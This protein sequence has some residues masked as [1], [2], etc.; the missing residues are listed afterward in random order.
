MLASF[1]S[2][3]GQLVLKCLQIF[4]KTNENGLL[5]D[6]K[7]PKGHFKINWPLPK[8]YEYPDFFFFGKIDSSL[9][10]CTFSVKWKL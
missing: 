10:A 9:Y 1:A 8:E 5:E 2:S 3:R 6:L 7:T 4:Q